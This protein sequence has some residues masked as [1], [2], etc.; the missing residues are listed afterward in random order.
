MTPRGRVARACEQW[1]PPLLPTRARCCLATCRGIRHTRTRTTRCSLQTGRSTQH[2][3]RPLP[4]DALALSHTLCCTPSCP[5]LPCPALP[6]PPAGHDPRPHGGAPLAHVPPRALQVAAAA[7][8]H[9]RQF[10]VR[11]GACRPRGPR[12]MNHRCKVWQLSAL[13][14]LGAPIHDSWCT[15][16]QQLV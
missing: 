6:C 2:P 5:A 11:T 4:P 13:P 9:H 16:T 3:F 7:G 8:G 10:P 12:H 14:G 1:L 15:I